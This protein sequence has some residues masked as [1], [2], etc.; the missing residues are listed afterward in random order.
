MSEG[1]LDILL[2]RVID[3]RATGEDWRRLEALA[4]IDAGVWR[5]LALAQRDDALLRQGMARALERAGQVTLPEGHPAGSVAM[6][7]ARTRLVATWGGWGVAAMVAVALLTRPGH[8]TPRGGEQI[9]GSPIL[10]AADALHT[11]LEKGRQ[12]GV[13]I[14]EMPA[15][16]LVQSAP[17]ANG[18]GFDVVYLRVIMER[19]QV[20][21][22][23]KFSSDEFGS[24]VPVRLGTPPRRTTGDGPV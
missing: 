3:G 20:P 21:D 1:E 19:T 9:A 14:E 18:R 11:Y 8:E 10:T 12:E 2:T 6:T 7:R 23:Y 15:K 13:V 5:E 4:Q 24:T 17:A 22:L 16:W